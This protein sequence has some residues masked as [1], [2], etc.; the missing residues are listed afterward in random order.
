MWD[1]NAPLQLL[2][3]MPQKLSKEHLERLQLVIEADKYKNSLMS[4]FDLC[5]MYA[6]FCR[7]CEK[8]SIY[9][10]ALS[11]INMMRARGM[12]IEIDA[13]PV[14]DEVSQQYVPETEAI[15]QP[16]AQPVAEKQI[17]Q[18]AAA[19]SEPERE[20]VQT[21]EPVFTEP[22]SQEA[23]PEPYVQPAAEQIVQ[24]VARPLPEQ[25][26]TQVKRKIR[27]AVARRKL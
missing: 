17:I 6:P 23:C 5:G 14:Y 24:P 20:E 19:T 26:Q 22:Q 25:P 10:C 1:S 11:Y 9:P 13:K 16:I 7:G 27:I 12:A 8:T 4:G 18:E 3:T 15:E 21:A 2:Q